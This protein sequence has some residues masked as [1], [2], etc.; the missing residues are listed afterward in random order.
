MARQAA[1]PAFPYGGFVAE[2]GSHQSPTAG[3][4]FVV[5]GTS[6]GGG[7]SGRPRLIMR[8]PTPTDAPRGTLVVTLLARTYQVWRDNPVTRRRDILAKFFGA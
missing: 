8:E 1:I 5:E 2:T 4:M 6:G 3:P 7:A